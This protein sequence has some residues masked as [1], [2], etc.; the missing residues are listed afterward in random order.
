VFVN[1]VKCLEPTPGYG[2][3]FYPPAV[4]APRRYP[5]KGG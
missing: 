3:L 4:A 1:M 2:R 5:R